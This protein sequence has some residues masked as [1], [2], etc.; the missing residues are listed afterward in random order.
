MADIFAAFNAI[1]ELYLSQ[2][3]LQVIYESGFA[4]TPPCLRNTLLTGKKL[5]NPMKNIGVRATL[6]M[7][8]I[9]S[10][11]TQLHRNKKKMRRF[12]NM[13]IFLGNLKPNVRK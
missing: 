2:T 1:S 9:T 10:R 5:E 11:T 6:T 3:Q 4:P 12:F 8:L 7:L 13:E